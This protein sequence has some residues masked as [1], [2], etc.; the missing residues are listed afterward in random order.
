[1][2]DK[3]LK[4][5]L[6]G[7]MGALLPLIL[8]Y[9]LSGKLDNPNGVIKHGELCIVI[10]GMCAVGL[11]EILGSGQQWKKATR[12]AGSLTLFCLVLATGL[13]ATAPFNSNLTP[14]YMAI[15]SYILFAFAFFS[16]GVCVAISEA[17]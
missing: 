6:T 14:D 16:C 2:L 5:L 17:E 12:L 13:Y 1:M 10:A 4:W 7:V 15:W 3:L 11:G 8:A 9:I